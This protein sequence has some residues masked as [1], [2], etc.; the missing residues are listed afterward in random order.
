MRRTS[1]NL[2]IKF[3][4]FIT[5]YQENDDSKSTVEPDS[6]KAEITKHYLSFDERNNGLTLSFPFAKK[7]LF[8]DI[9]DQSASK[10]EAINVEAHPDDKSTEEKVNHIKMN[11]KLIDNTNL[12]ENEKS[13][14]LV[15]DPLP[16]GSNIMEEAEATKENRI[17][18]EILPAV[19]EQKERVNS[20]SMMTQEHQNGEE[21]KEDNTFENGGQI[22]VH[23][24]D[25]QPKS[26]NLTCL[27]TFNNC[28]DSP[29][30]QGSQSMT[31][32]AQNLE[33]LIRRISQ[34]NCISSFQILSELQS[35][36]IHCS[37][38]KV[39]ILDFNN[40]N[41]NQG[42]FDAAPTHQEVV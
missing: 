41:I 33:S 25:S 14:G 17:D 9:F 31:K 34:L 12:N 6:Q 22:L 32:L 27:S 3:S 38:D 19:E 21:I 42:S 23:L 18:I 16:D 2:N 8:K 5:Y 10:S 13:N 26:N 39:I 11:G 36:Y 24:E 28:L 30:R 29:H 35:V 4:L 7:D 1:I 20:L 40:F 15:L 37:K